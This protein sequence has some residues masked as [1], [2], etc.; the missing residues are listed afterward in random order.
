MKTLLVSSLISLTLLNTG[1]TFTPTLNKVNVIGG[2]EF[3][4]IVTTSGYAPKSLDLGVAKISTDLSKIQADEIQKLTDQKKLEE[5]NKAREEQ[6]QKDIEDQQHQEAQEAVRKSSV[7]KLSAPAPAPTVVSSAPASGDVQGYAKNRVC[8]V[9]GCDNWDAFYFIILKESTWNPQAVNPTSGAG[10][11]CQALPFSKMESKGADYR[12]NPNTQ[13]E[14]CI[15]Y[16]QGRYG[17][18][19]GAKTFWT[20]NN[21]F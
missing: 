13:I 11:L 19:N 17:N 1:L 3:K 9:F 14:W 12:S 8:E 7:A 15:S 20:A 4:Q 6:Q 21:W 2:S 18:P 16:I 5:E 10:G